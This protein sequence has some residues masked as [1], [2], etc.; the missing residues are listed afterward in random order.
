MVGAATPTFRERKKADDFIFE[1]M[2]SRAWQLLQGDP[3]YSRPTAFS[4]VIKCVVISK[5]VSG[6]CLQK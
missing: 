2:D 4:W 6:V 3:C 5:C 1:T